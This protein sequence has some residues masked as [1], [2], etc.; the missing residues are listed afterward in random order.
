MTLNVDNLDKLLLTFT[1]FELSEQNVETET[2]EVSAK[3]K[4]LNF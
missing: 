4:E 2:I 3:F 1:D